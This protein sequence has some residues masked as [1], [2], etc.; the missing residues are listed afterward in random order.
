[1]KSKKEKNKIIIIATITV[2]II[3]FILLGI[4][5]FDKSRNKLEASL[6]KKLPV[7]TYRASDLTL[8]QNLGNQ[9]TFD[10]KFKTF[11]NKKYYYKWVTYKDGGKATETKC[12]PIANGMIVRNTLDISAKY[13]YGK[14]GIYSED[15]CIL[16]NAA[17]YTFTY[18]AKDLINSDYNTLVANFYL[19]TAKSISA[20]RR[21]CTKKEDGSC[22]IT[23]PTIDAREGFEV[24]G[25][26]TKRDGTGEGYSQGSEI[27]L[28]KDINLYAITKRKG[29]V[30]TT[31][32]NATKKFAVTFKRNGAK[33]IGAYYLSCTTDS[34][35]CKIQ[36]PSIT[37]KDGYEVIGW[38]LKS[39]GSGYNYKTGVNLI[40]DRNATL[41]A[42]TKKKSNSGVSTTNNQGSTKKFT[43]T[44]NKNDALAVQKKSV[45]CT[46]KTDSCDVILPAAFAK[47]GYEVLGWHEDKN[48]KV[49]LYK[50][51]FKLNVNRNVNLYA[52]TRKKTTAKIS[53]T[54]YTENWK[55]G[56]Q[57]S[58][59]VKVTP[60]TE[61]YK[62]TSSNENV[63]VV[64]NDVL[65]AVGPGVA[66][67]T[68]TSSPS[69]ATVS[70]TYKVTGID[71]A[72]N[73]SRLSKG[74]LEQYKRGN[75]NI[76][77]EKG[78]PADKVK[79]IKTDI[80]EIPYYL[81]EST[82]SIYLLT[83]STYKNKAG[84]GSVGLS[85]LGGVNNY[86]DVMCDYSSVS[87]IINHEV[88][89]TFDWYAQRIIGKPYFHDRKD[90]LALKEEYKKLNKLGNES[91]VEFYAAM[92]AHHYRK[93]YAKT[94]PIKNDKWMSSFPYP[95]N[96]ENKMNEYIN[97]YL[98]HKK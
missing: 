11:D 96:M 15:R 83:S 10:A 45:S 56:T 22:T 54:R 98:N 28:T 81:L 43:V 52:I 27:T 55:V 18:S 19:N 84:E 63:M 86:I 24:V 57:G 20:N 36:L 30:V 35:K 67:I 64:Y 88:G 7:V 37:P 4:F 89:H 13:N 85:H 59:N 72:N 80:N 65:Y 50:I 31:S 61:N 25:W 76:Y 68:A 58:L 49:P 74:V 1:M 34:D 2:F 94:Y 38:N 71:N 21:S 79:V 91:N 53:M 39:D 23:L 6:I 12:K 17:Y 66:T 78:C 93:N 75:V 90:F 69:G 33:K 42:I 14:W 44:L 29:S 70:Y 97:E 87:N 60:N 62:V 46:T 95:K 16:Q 3:L 47:K 77:I 48:A 32:S 8:L 26:N 41:Y 40:L 82:R 73:L 9:I 5:L 51:G 92:F